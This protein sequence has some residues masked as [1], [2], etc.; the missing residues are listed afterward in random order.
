MLHH[1]QKI[2]SFATGCWISLLRR[3]K[4]NVQLFTEYDSAIRD[5]LSHGVVEVINDPSSGKNNL[6]MV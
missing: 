5:Q 4:Q 3:L 6:I 2:S 1:S